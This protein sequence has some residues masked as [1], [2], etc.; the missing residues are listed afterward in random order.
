MSLPPHVYPCV[1]QRLPSS[2]ETPPSYRS[3]CVLYE[4]RQ[5]DQAHAAFKQALTALADSLRVQLPAISEKAVEEHKER[6]RGQSGTLT[7]AAPVSRPRALSDDTYSGSDDG[8]DDPTSPAPSGSPQPPA[9]PPVQS[10][11]LAARS[12]VSSS[13]GLSASSSTPRI[14]IDESLS[15]P[16]PTRP[17]S[18]SHTPADY[19][20]IQPAARSVLAQLHNAVLCQRPIVAA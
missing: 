10:T 20:H 16:P 17:M 14:H 8:T 13:T 5:F 9:S 15:S 12:P 7:L 2:V 1:L 3:G 4:Q 19:S 6:E 11:S 18:H